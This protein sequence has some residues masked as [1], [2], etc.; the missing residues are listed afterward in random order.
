[1]VQ[2][3]PQQPEVVSNGRK[4]LA[5]CS[6]DYLGLANHPDVIAAFKQ[7]LDT[8]GAGSGASHLVAGHSRAHHVLEEELAAFTGRSRALVFSSGFMANVG[9]LGALAAKQDHVF[10]DRLNHASL[11]DGGMNSGAVFRRYPHL[12]MT[13]LDTLLAKASSQGQRFIVSDGVFSMDGDVAP[14]AGL[15]ATAERHHAVVM[16]DDA[17]GF[18]VL[19]GTGGGL[20]QAVGE[21]GCDTSEA[22]LA[23]LVGT[24]GKAF[25]TAGAFVAGS[26]E[27]I[28][29]L[30]Q[31][32]RPY[33]YTT[34]LPPALAVATR[35]SL[36]LVQQEDWRRWHL[37][38]LVNQFRAGCAELKLTLTDSQTPIQGLLLGAADTALRVS[39]QLEERG[40]LVSAIRPPTVPGGTARLRISFSALHT[41]A[42]VKLLLEA[43]ATIAPTLPAYEAQTA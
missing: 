16:L 20:A 17:H 19:G 41:V 43:L 10:E 15:L 33:I 31:F 21:Q 32:C 23:I 26:E 2:D 6:N 42:Q 35:R 37:R 7:G 8:Y 22:R 13:Q 11:L 4:M 24:F 39:R 14:L 25:G 36:Q 27:L 12:D 29:T 9:V 34:A 1:R 18:G 38:A 5:F 40:I 3:S 28:E 30:I